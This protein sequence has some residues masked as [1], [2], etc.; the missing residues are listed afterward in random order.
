MGQAEEL[1]NSLTPEQIAAYS[2]DNTNEPHIVISSDRFITVPDSLKRIAVEADHNIETVTFDC[3]RYW[4]NHDLSKMILYINYKLSNGFTGSYIAENIT[5]DGDIIHFTWTI[6]RT[7]AAVKGKIIFLVCA[8][9]TDSEGNEENHWNSELNTEMYVSEGL[10]CDVVV[11]DEYPDIVTQLLERMTVVEGINVQ[12][13]YIDSQVAAANNAVELATDAK[14]DAGDILTDVKGNAAEIRNSYANAIKGKVTGELVKV[15]DVSPLV[16]NPVVKVHGKNFLDIPDTVVEGNYA[17]CNTL[18]GSFDLDP[19]TYT[20]S[21]D[22]V[23]QGTDIS[24]IS[25]SPRKYEEVT[26][27]Y[28]SISSTEESGSLK[29]TFTIPAN[30]KGF[31]LYAYSNVTANVL[32]TRCTFSNFQIEKGTIAT[33]YTP[34]ID[35]STVKVT[36]CGKAIFSK[37]TQ[38]VSGVSKPWT[39]LL[40]AAVKVPPGDYVVSCRFNQIGQD[41]S[42]VGISARSYNDYTVPF[43]DDSSS[44]KSGYLEKAFTVPSGS[45][46]FQIF[47]YSNMPNEPLTTE[48]SFENICVEVGSVATGY[49]LY[50]GAQYTPATDG[51]VSGITSISPNMTIFTDTEGVVV[52]MEYN[53]DT[54]K[55]FESYVLTDKAKSEI[56]SEVE[57]DMAE[58]LA[59]L[60]SYAASVISGGISE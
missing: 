15:D 58:V 23:Q 59:S 51:S 35:A 13:E 9:K 22:F 31:S 37:S 57:S 46:G 50:N 30:E 29:V 19:G 49:S 25:I 41:M 60:N 55:M 45:G 18:I 53:R 38:I 5:V 8:K 40:V 14:D 4:D 2:V 28:G 26:V 42:T 1:L 21:V 24:K 47:L 39:S 43:G 44:E 48:C 11:E 27:Q 52:E 36:R 10:E 16:H 56:A 7:V 6:T 54:T 12:K 20:L 33:E 32:E 17:W 3:P 34:F